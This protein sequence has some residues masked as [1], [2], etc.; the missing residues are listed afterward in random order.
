MSQGLAMRQYVFPGQILQSQMQYNKFL[1]SREPTSR[2]QISSKK[3]QTKRRDQPSNY[4]KKQTFFIPPESKKVCITKVLAFGIFLFM[5]LS[6][7][8]VLND[9]Y[10][11][12]DLSRPSRPAD[13]EFFPGVVIFFRKPHRYLCTSWVLHTF[14]VTSCTI[15]VKICSLLC[16]YF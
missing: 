5:R 16:H 12:W 14:Y 8:H 3:Y 15:G 4:N 11:T 7:V 13:M 1:G 2:Q 9:D 6:K 10:H